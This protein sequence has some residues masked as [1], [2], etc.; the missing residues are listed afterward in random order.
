[1][2]PLIPF[3]LTLASVAAMFF[4]YKSGVRRHV[5][6]FCMLLTAAAAAAVAVPALVTGVPVAW[7]P[8]RVDR[9][10]AYVVCLVAFVAAL[11]SLAGTHYIAHARRDSTLSSADERMFFSFFLLFVLSMWTAVAADN[12]A[13]L[14]IAL[15]STT[16]T[17]TLLV[18]FDRTRGAVEAA[19]KYI[20]I[21]S[22]GITLGLL[23]VLMLIQSAT[24]AELGS[25]ALTLSSLS[26]HAGSLSAVTLQWAFV[27][28]F[29]GVGTKVGFVPMH[30]WLP[31][32]HSKTPSP[33]S[34][35]L[36]GILLN[37]AFAV[38]LRVKPI[39]DAA[40]GAPEWTGRLFLVFGLLSVALPTFVMLVQ[41][42][43]KRMLAYSSIEHMGLMAFAAGL[44]PTGTLAAVIH[45]AGHA[46]AKPALFVG[47]GEMLHEYRS[48]RID[49]VRDVIRRRPKTAVLFFVALLALLAAPPSALFVSEFMMASYGMTR[50]PLL[51]IL[52]LAMLAII[53]F[54]MM[55][56]AVEMLFSS[57]A[58]AAD[59]HGAHAKAAAPARGATERWN[60]AN[61]AML[62]D[63]ILC[64]AL[65]IALLSGPG[66]AFFVTLSRSIS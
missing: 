31:D 2:H 7:G 5:F 37:V 47:A 50:H 8:V 66:Y 15:E 16:L 19:W 34:A 27:F 17:T 23:G 60:L 57:D 49:E 13:L 46:F 18:A 41:K 35:M 25:G 36:S 28:L 21:C 63:I 12:L 3:I 44:G 10:A 1:M 56:S 6:V 30:T 64:L 33:I 65:G 53:A 20:V 9:F 45:M 51:T 14:W 52:L 24:G 42:N 39:V 40:I 4:P 55:R 22:T 62:V 61:G 59:A 29:I 38:L 32:A 26:A 54:G 48:T 43:Y 58:P 11:A